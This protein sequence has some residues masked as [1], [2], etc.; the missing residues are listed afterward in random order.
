MNLQSHNV[1]KFNRFELKYIL[2]IKQAENLKSDLLAYLEPDSHGNSQGSYPV[3]S[4]YYD[5]PDLRCYWEKVEGIKFRRKLR[6]RSYQPYDA[7]FPDD[8]VFVEIKQRVDRITQKKR[9]FITYQQALN[10]CQDEKQPDNEDLDQTI[11]NE[12]F[13]Y[14]FHYQLLPTAIVRYQRQALIGTDYDLGLRV[15]FDT[16]ITGQVSPLHL[17]ES[18]NMLPILSPDLCVMEIKVNERIPYWITEL[19]AIHNLQLTRISKYCRCIEANNLQYKS[20][21]LSFM[22]T[23]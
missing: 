20:S 11:C 22:H 8:N 12:I 14:K 7:L 5:S 4:L 9:I 3:S 1:R 16:Q 6:I 19:V 17:H 15:T 10:L 21:L 18:E 2:P 13:A 23:S